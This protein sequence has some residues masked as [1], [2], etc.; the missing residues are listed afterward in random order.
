MEGVILRGILPTGCLLGKT[1]N[2]C[3]VHVDAVK[4][5]SRME[6]QGMNNCNED[7]ENQQKKINT[8]TTDSHPQIKSYITK[9]WK[10]ID[11]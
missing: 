6:L 11:L 8:I 7:F 3:L 1:L 2:F 9:E 4:H 10:D 5:S